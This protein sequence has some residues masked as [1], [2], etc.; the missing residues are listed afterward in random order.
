MEEC[1]LIQQSTRNQHPTATY[2]DLRRLPNGLG[3]AC[4]L[5]FQ[6][7]FRLT[8]VVVIFVANVAC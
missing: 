2:R 4:S 3:S 8:E 6:P 7:L 5:E 1:T